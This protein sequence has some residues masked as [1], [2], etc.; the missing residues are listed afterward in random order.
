[1]SREDMRFLEIVSHSAKLLDGHCNL[2]MAFR[3]EQLTLRNN[4]S[5]ARQRVLRLKRTFEKNERYY[6]EY[7]GFFTDVISKGYAEKIPEHQLDG[8]EGKV[9]YIPHHGVYHSRKNTLRVLFDCGATFKGT[10]LNSH[11]LQG[12]N[13]TGALLGVL[14]RFRQ[15][16][17]ALM[18]DIQQ[19]FFQVQITDMDKDLLRSLW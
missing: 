4:L 19:M 5:V 2:K 6:Q 9:W 7:A 17:V 12:P 16:P 18:G 13:L 8:G 1:M 11:L 10:S 14:T 15:E 3:K